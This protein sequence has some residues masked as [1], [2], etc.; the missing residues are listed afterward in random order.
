[1]GARHRGR[2]RPLALA[3]RAALAVGAAGV[4]GV[5]YGLWEAEN[6]VLRRHSLAVLPAGSA[7]IRVLHLS[8]IHLL[9][10]HAGRMR[11]IRELDRLAPDLVVNTGDNIAAAASIGPL[12]EALGPLLD[13]PGVFVPGSND[14][15]EP[16]SANPFRYFAGPSRLD[17][18][19]P[20]LP[21][22]QLFGAFR[23]AGWADLTN[24]SARVRAG[25]EG[26][27]V[28]VLAVGTDDPHLGL[29]DWPGFTDAGEK[30]GS[31]AERSGQEPVLR[32]GVTHAPYR[33]VLDAMV[34]DGAGLVLA[35]H[36]H[37]GQ[38]CLP[39]VGA[40]VT[41]CDLPRRQASGLSSWSAQGRTAPLEVC[42]GLGAAPSM[43]VRTFC[44]PEAVLLELTARP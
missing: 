43:P 41:N 11:W 21:T 8:D 40:L 22:E 7:P 4:V 2:R 6:R 12:L 42:A 33:R 36:T 25:A 19:R 17:E 10:H 37:G 24:R 23:A 18:D 14:Y 13:R 9:P 38:V 3:G 28:E 44:R 34:A 1:M 35:G 20:H 5:G 16:K 32:L 31:A 27:A 15:Y 30:E 26:A 39:F 29:D